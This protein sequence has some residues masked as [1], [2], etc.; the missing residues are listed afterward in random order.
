[1]SYLPFTLKTIQLAGDLVLKMAEKHYKIEEKAKNDLVTE[2]DKASEKFITKAIKKAYPTHAILGEE[3]FFKNGLTDE[4]RNAKYIWIVDPIDGTLNFTRGLP[5][6]AIS[7]ALFEK[8]THEV[9]KNYNYLSG[10]IIAG[11]VL[12]PRMKELFYAEKGKGAYLNGK[13]IHVTDCKKVESSVLATGFH[14]KGALQNLPYFKK[15]AGNCRGIRRFGASAI[16]LAYTACGHFDGYWEFNIK[17]WDIAAGCIIIEEAGG[18]VTDLNG[19]TLDL[20]GNQ[21]LATNGKIHKEM[22]RKLNA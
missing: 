19:N 13:K 22:I 7:I 2:V 12:I 5:Y 8:S 20:F 16:D 11:A 15:V 10:E 3:D 4:I 17:A 9:S 21:I 1:M 6:F 18:K 14:L